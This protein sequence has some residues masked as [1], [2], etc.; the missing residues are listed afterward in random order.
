MKTLKTTL[1]IA[2]QL[3]AVASVFAVIYLFLLL[4]YGAGMTM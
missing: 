1:N 3:L 4:G 2:L